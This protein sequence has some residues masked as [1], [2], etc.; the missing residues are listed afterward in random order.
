MIRTSFPRLSCVLA[1]VAVLLPG[2]L[3][4]NAEVKPACPFTSH[5]VLQRDMKVPVWGTAQSGEDVTVAF[6]G[7]K[8]SVKAG[9]DGTWRVDLDPLSA[10]A[11]GRTLTLTGSATAQPVQLDDVLVGEVW[12]ASGQSNMTFPISKAHASYAGVNNEEQEIAA[13]NYPLIRMFMG[14][15][16]KAH[17]PQTSVG[18]QWLVCSPATAPDFSAVGYFFARDLQKELKVPVGILTVA[19]GASTA[20]A[21]IRRDTLA[22]DP[23]LKPMLDQYDAAYATFKADP[24]A[25]AKYAEAKKQHEAAAA[26]ALAQGQKPTRGPPDPD[27][28]QNQHNS[29]VLFNAMINPVL[30]YAIR[31][32]IWYQG[33]SIVNSANGGR[34]LYPHVMETLVRDWRQLWGEGDFPFYIVQLA[35]LDN[36]SNNPGVREAQAAVLKLKNTGMAVTIDIGDPKNV[37]P[38]DKQDVGD[39]LTRIALANAYGHTLEFSGPM[40]DSMKV[41]GGAIRL[42]FTHLGGGLVAKD[43]PLK[44]FV[45]AGADMN[46]VPADAKIDGDSVVVSSAQVPTPAAVRYAWSN[47]PDGCNLYNAAGLP[48]APFRTDNEPFPVPPPPAPTPPAPAS[49]PTSPAPSSAP[50]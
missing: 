36:A 39:R 27:P 6:A 37:H 9:A 4:L 25:A 30:P 45:I 23:L 3:P 26:Q 41:E 50:H 7:Q 42:S 40:Y 43:P 22:A 1:I 29:T 12:L 11:E 14:T 2:F 19:F 13:A 24:N 46:F 10:S 5:M 38:K 34:A 33:E 20:E 32:V 31:G 47:Y 8:K 18:G 16:T 21:W 15:M 48:A 44:W 35:A 28:S 17:D 49:A